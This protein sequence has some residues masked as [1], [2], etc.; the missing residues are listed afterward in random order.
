MTSLT[1]EEA[2]LWN[3]T[4]SQRWRTLLEKHPEALRFACDIRE[5]TLVRDLLQ[6]IVGAE[7]R[8]AERLMGDPVTD[9]ADIPKMTIEEL[10]GVHDFAIAKFRTL[11]E[12]DSYDWSRE[13][14]MDTRSEGTLI[15]PRRAVLFHALMHS[16]RH[17]AQLA[18][19]LRHKGIPAGFEMDYFLVSAR[20]G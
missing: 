11:V 12:D 7:L 19:I 10:Y 13:L 18:T 9:Y 8:Y 2:I 6:H 15:A 5:S 14:E 16:L 17:Y 4:T 1:A 3:D 20:K